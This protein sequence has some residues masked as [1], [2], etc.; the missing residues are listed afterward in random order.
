MRALCFTTSQVN[1]DLHY[2]KISNDRNIHDWHLWHLVVSST[3]LCPIV[4]RIWMAKQLIA[5]LNEMKLILKVYKAKRLMGLTGHHDGFKSTNS[6]EWQSVATSLRKKLI[7]TWW[8]N[9]KTDLRL[10]KT[11]SSNNDGNLSLMGLNEL[12]SNLKCDSFSIAW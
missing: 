8:S 2:I 6:L 5:C 3:H 11:T 1:G 12:K 7:S 9:W 10:S 4:V